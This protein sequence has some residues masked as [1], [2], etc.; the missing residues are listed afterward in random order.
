MHAIQ[1]IMR[2][3]NTNKILQEQGVIISWGV[4]EIE[5]QQ[6]ENES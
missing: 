2:I 4:A 3:I 1:E 6:E 5:L